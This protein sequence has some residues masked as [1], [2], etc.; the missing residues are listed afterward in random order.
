MLMTDTYTYKPRQ[1]EP[2]Y[3]WAVVIGGRG[4]FYGACGPFPTREEAVE[5][6]RA[7]IRDAEERWEPVR[8]YAKADYR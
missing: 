8:L 3:M 4:E 5:W 6:G 2:A 1:S 7:N